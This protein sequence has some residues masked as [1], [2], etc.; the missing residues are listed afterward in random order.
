[1]KPVSLDAAT[2]QRDPYAVYSL[3]REQYPV[4]Q[5]ESGPQFAISRYEDV[6]AALVDSDRFTSGLD[7]I[8]QPPWLAKH[9]HRSLFILT[10][11]QP[12][13]SKHRRL[14]NK[15]FVGETLLALEDPLRNQVQHLMAE[16]RAHGTV[17]FP[18]TFAF[19]Y[20]GSIIN[21]LVGSEGYQDLD[22]LRVQLALRERMTPTR[23]SDSEVEAIETALE[24][25]NRAFNAL[26][27]ARRLAPQNDLI[28][29][30]INARIDDQPLSD[31]ELR[32]ALDLFLSAG[33]HTTAHTLTI[34]IMY[35]ANM[36]ELFTQ[37]KQAPELISKFIEELLRYSSPTHYILRKTI[38]EIEL[39]GV[40]IPPN[41]FISLVVA[42]ANR[43]PA[44]FADPDRFELF[45]P[46]IKQHLAFAYG[47][48]ACIG[49]ALARLE[50]RIALE[51]LITEFNQ[52]EC[53][54]LA[55]IPWEVT[56]TTRGVRHL[57]VR[58][59]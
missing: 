14:V 9:L 4:C 35:L 49:S 10:M 51:G 29:T 34:A 17:D 45:R 18:S 50:L 32:G 36:P 37:L 6:R 1:M 28:S 19:P 22:T 23:P 3:M 59:S 44:Q 33:Y 55:E 26:I 15:S 27:H 54:P 46:N 41:S 24:N 13:H 56:S 40:L 20:V 16:I 48:H 53:L 52:F 58:F 38:C 25:Q 11:D 12:E 31:Y 30:L 43:D 21:S 47:P 7:S 8:V 39:H 5:L 57:K 42:A 2:L